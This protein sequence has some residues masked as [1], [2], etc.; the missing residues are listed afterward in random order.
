MLDVPSLAGLHLSATQTVYIL[1]AA[2][3]YGF[4]ASQHEERSKHGM[5]DTQHM[6][7]C[8]LCGMLLAGLPIWRE[9][10]GPGHVLHV[11]DL[12]VFQHCATQTS[13]AS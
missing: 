8:H 4:A 11:F 3:L 5:P 13:F 6:I 10:G 7:R 2:V 9:A 12:R 1:A